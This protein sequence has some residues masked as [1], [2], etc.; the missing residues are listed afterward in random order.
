MNGINVKAYSLIKDGNIQLSKNFKVKEFACKDGSDTVF[1][2]DELVS[3]VQKIRDHYGKSV[4]INSG[5]RT[6]SHNKKVGGAKKS[7]H[8]VGIA[9]DIMVKGVSPA[10]V[11]AYA[12]TL[13]PEHGGIG[14]YKNFV[15]I[16]VRHEKS[17][18]HGA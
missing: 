4:T 10:K 2:S 17:R 6:F 11:A 5:Y 3:L 15:H 12:E 13:M 7:T 14:Q 16:D 8:L 1:I 9:A 18:W